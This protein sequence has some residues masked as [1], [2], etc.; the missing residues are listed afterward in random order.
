M[1]SHRRVIN[2][3]ELAD[4]GEMNLRGRA[5]QTRRRNRGEGG[6]ANSPG[7]SEGEASGRARPRS[8]ETSASRI[9]KEE[10]QRNASSGLVGWLTWPAAR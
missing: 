3:P 2:P 5:S 6:R 1:D 10:N 8:A 7:F 9:G 4:E